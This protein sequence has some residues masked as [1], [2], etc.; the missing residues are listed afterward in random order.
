MQDGYALNAYISKQPHCG[1]AY[2]WISDNK[3]EVVRRDVPHIVSSVGSS[4]DIL[5]QG[6]DI[7]AD[8]MVA[9]ASSAI[10]SPSL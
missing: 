1:L 7:L 9:R 6:R 5:H 8:F 2:R 3:Q 10:L 4:F